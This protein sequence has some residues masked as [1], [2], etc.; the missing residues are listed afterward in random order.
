METLTVFLIILAAIIALGIAVFSYRSR[1]PKHPRLA[2]G[3]AFLRFLSVFGLL[4]LLIDPKLTKRQVTI[5][6]P[7]LVLVMDNSR[8]LKDYAHVVSDLSDPLSTDPVLRERFTISEYHF[9]DKLYPGDSLDFTGAFTNLSS[10][11]AQLRQLYANTSTAVVL[12]TDGNATLGGDYTAI[13]PEKGFRV[14]PMV[15]GDT[16]HH[17]DLRVDR[18]NS[19][20]YTFLGNKFPI[21]AFVSYEG[22]GDVVT[23]ATI[24]LDGKRVFQERLHFGPG[25]NSATIRTQ[26]TAGS[27]G[28][29]S[30]TVALSPLENERN[31]NNNVR[32]LAIEVIDEKTDVAIIS[33]IPHP[34][35]GALVRAIESNGQRST[36]R[37]EPTDPVSKW[38]DADLVVLYQP[39]ARFK[40][41]YAQLKKTGQGRLTVTGARVDANALNSFQ[42]SF[43]VEPRSPVFE[44]FP[45][46]DPTFSKFDVSDFPVEGLPPLRSGAG[47]VSTHGGEPLFRA[48]MRGV[49][50]GYPLIWAREEEN[51]REIAVFGEDIWKW[52]MAD[53]RGTGDFTR[54]DAVI[55][56][57]IRYLAA[58]GDRGRLTLDYQAQY[59]GNHNV[60]IRATY[61]D[62]AFEPDPNAKLVLEVATAG[63]P[64]S[65][66]IPM[67]PKE[68]YFEVR[69]PDLDPGDYTFTVNVPDQGL[70]RSGKFSVLD[71]D[72]EKQFW[73]SDYKRLTALANASG[74][75]VFYP[76]KVRTLIDTLAT[77]PRFRP[78]Q[79][80]TEKVVSLVDFRLVLALI[81][82]ALAMEWFL[83][84]YHG[85]A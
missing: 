12:V 69:I 75:A 46:L 21:E 84:K 43:V 51:H 83:R 50:S 5:D 42:N 63:A 73:S 67:L 55:G 59:E 65:Q 72:I 22:Q 33:A 3:L 57:W 34:D 40:Q 56:K 30:I 26:V 77:D 1:Y 27:I 62:E 61:V 28:L 79:R 49:E 85:I 80:T 29:K 9:S 31:P 10:T 13:A 52:R 66:G 68:T 19:N 14:F 7:D 38:E 48:K 8:S 37:F 4:L 15:V 76:G 58:Q 36:T 70:V 39:D 78:V 23:Q 60:A 16:V 17:R 82:L 81:V 45:V 71:F 11:L 2:L 20:R 25:N 35:I 6:K 74:A 44:M 47:M 18:A 24:S 54:F 53:Y 64:R 32:R 41:V